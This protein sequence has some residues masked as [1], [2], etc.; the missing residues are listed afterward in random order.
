MLS[1]NRVQGP[2]NFIVDKE[3]KRKCE[4]YVSDPQKQILQ[5]DLC[6]INKETELKMLQ[7]EK[8]SLEI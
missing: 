3:K 5:T 4:E 1:P 8:V 7:K 2:L 6:R